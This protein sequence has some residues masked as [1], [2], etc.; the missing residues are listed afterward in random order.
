[1]K[2]IVLNLFLLLFCYTKSF[3]QIGV[4]NIPIANECPNN[5]SNDTSGWSIFYA[6]DIYNQTDFLS[7]TNSPGINYLQGSSTITNVI[8][9]NAN[10]HGDRVS[11]IPFPD[12]LNEIGSICLSQQNQT[13]YIKIGGNLEIGGGSEEISRSYYL[14]I[15]NPKLKIASYVRFSSGNGSQYNSSTVPFFKYKIEVRYN[16]GTKS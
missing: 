16:D 5:Q 14:S 2:N 12:L 8:E 11:I 6:N 4:N 9:S 3:G 1:M 15:S 13:N 10:G 7:S